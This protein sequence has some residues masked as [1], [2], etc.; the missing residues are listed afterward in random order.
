[1]IIYAH[2]AESPLIFGAYFE[3]EKELEDWTIVDSDGDGYNWEWY[4]DS[5]YAYEGSGSMKSSSWISGV[6][7]LSPD[8]WLVSPAITLPDSAITLSFYEY[9]SSIYP[10]TFAVFVAPA[11]A[12]A[13]E[14]S[15]DGSWEQVS[16]DFTSSGEYVNHIVDLSMFAGTEVYIAIRHY[17]CYDGMSMYID[18]FEVAKGIK[19]TLDA[20]GGTVETDS[21]VPNSGGKLE[22]IPVAT[23]D[24]YVFLGWFTEPKGGEQ[25]TTE[26]I[27]TEDTTI[28]AHWGKGGTVVLGTYFE[29]E[30]EIGDWAIIDNDGDGYNWEWMN[31]EENA[32]YAYEGQGFMASASYINDLGALNP[33]NWLISPVAELPQGSS[34]VSFWAAGQDPSWAAEVFAIYA[35]PADKDISEIAFPDDWTKISEDFKASGSYNNFSAD[36]TDFAGQSVYVAIRHYNITDMFRL[37]VDA[38]VIQ[39]ML[40]AHDIIID[41]EIEGGSVSADLE[42]AYCEDLVTLSY[43][44]QPG[45]TFESWNVTDAEGN[46]IEVADDNTFVM[47]D[48]DVTVSAVFTGGATEPTF[49]ATSLLLS[50]QIGVVF[51]Y[52]L[53]Q[54]DVLAYDSVDFTVTMPNSKTETSSW[55][56]SDAR[57]NDGLYGFVCYVNS[58]QM[59]DDIT[60]VLN[61]TENGEEKT[62]TVVSSVKEY[63]E[64][65]EKLEEGELTNAQI[66][67]HA[68]A[69]FGHYAQVYLSDARGWTIGT[70]YADMDI[71]YTKDFNA[72]VVRIAVDDLMPVIEKGE[73]ELASISYS[74]GLDSSTTL[75]IYANTPSDYTGSISATCD[76]VELE[77]EKVGKSFRFAIPD[78]K[79]SHLADMYDVI[80]KS[81]NERAA[82]SLAA[83]SYVG[84]VIDA[85]LGDKANDAVSAF[86]YYYAASLPYRMNPRN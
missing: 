53:P 79:A 26:T 19:V 85:Q 73:N 51:Y 71:F 83:L 69:D 17:N 61:Y 11:T 65:S 39:S 30:D 36:L 46:P 66:L 84:S 22:S 27:F 67:T 28:Y 57:E 44:E 15:Y 4:V 1:T 5:Q 81:D 3:T 41:E 38:F 59:A 33:D 32:P 52:D 7:A 74:L 23:W 16:D 37:N 40:Y 58:I 56:F 24:E 42:E 76:G 9:G 48:S 49:Y 77:A 50:G 2:W 14:L 72:E 34:R 35:A 68:V 45:Y 13:D 70:D 29:S 47:P 75:Y 80:I 62:L 60:A 10:E 31:E 12:A 25:I 64:N 21:V 8:N 82:V 86:Y 78:I 43:E 54:T 55:A 20:N 6:G 63:I 18:Q